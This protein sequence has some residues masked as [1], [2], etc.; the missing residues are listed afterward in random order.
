MPDGIGYSAS[1]SNYWYNNG[2]NTTLIGFESKLSS[3]RLSA[4]I[5]NGIALDT[6]S[7][8]AMVI[9]LKAGYNYDKNGIVG[10]NLRI[11]NNFSEGAVSTQF[12]YSPCTVNVPVAENTT[13]YLN[14]HG[15]AKYNYTN[16]EWDTSVG[17]FLGVTQNFKKGVSVSLEG[18]RYNIQEPHEND[19]NWGVN[20]II[21]KK[22]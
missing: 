10:Q 2:V 4:A 14:P 17:A 12:R 16:K 21:S 15:V 3:N 18:Q 9:D 19:G 20:F 22:F 6:K 1:C 5:F 11:R 7:G 13:V 8:G